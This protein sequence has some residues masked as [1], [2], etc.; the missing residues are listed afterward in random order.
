M[1]FLDRWAQ[2][3]AQ[4]SERSRWE[5]ERLQI[6]Q[7]VR[8]LETKYKARNLRFSLPFMGSV[9]VEA[10]GHID[11]MRF[12]FSYRQ[13][14]G[15]LRV[16]PCNEDLERKIYER[17]VRERD[18]H[19]IQ[20]QKAY[21][22][23][24]ITEDEFK[25][26]SLMHNRIVSENLADN[27]DFYPNEVQ[28]YSCVKNYAGQPRNGFLDAEECFDLFSQLADTLEAREEKDWV[29]DYVLEWLE[30]TDN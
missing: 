5:H 13:D 7:A 28:Y 30:G 27:D 24:E 17:A 25:Y 1:G 4:G 16:G 19:Q 26:R 6:V 29:P 23:G 15:Q 22:A 12:Y 18:T 14:T 3:F 20:D 11:G 10:F 9:P 2:E 21:E 8:R